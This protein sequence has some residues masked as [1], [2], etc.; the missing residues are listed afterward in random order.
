MH[1]IHETRSDLSYESR[2]PSLG[3]PDSRFRNSLRKLGIENWVRKLYQS[4]ERMSSTLKP[5]SPALP[6]FHL[7]RLGAWLPKNPK[8]VLDLGGGIGHYRDF[9]ASVEDRYLILEVDYA[10]YAVQ[11]NMERHSYVVGD[12]HDRLFADEAFDL[13]C[14]FEVLE[15]VRNPFTI[16][17]NCSRWLKPGGRMFIS[18]PQ[19]WHV[20]G[21]P[22]DYFRYTVNGIKELART[23]GLTVSEIWPMG[24][25]C[26]LILSVIE[27][28]FNF[29]RFPIMKELIYYPLLVFAKLGDRVFFRN[30]MQR[31]HPDSRGWVAVITKPDNHVAATE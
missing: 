21:W 4:Y 20:H 15:H 12:G 2:F 6:E 7:Q 16:F 13:I 8:T 29:L 26:V 27:L 18:A 14:L 17:S 9:A 19:Y 3:D 23:A 22:S 5:S 28:N 31:K 11:R 30:N 10:S 25:P 1:S 24:G